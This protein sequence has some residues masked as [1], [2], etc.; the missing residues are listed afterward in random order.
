[1]DTTSDQHVYELIQTLK[2]L[3]DSSVDK[4]V[5]Q[6]SLLNHTIYQQLAQI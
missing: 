2:E 4:Q 1:M 3:S 6:L 5:Q